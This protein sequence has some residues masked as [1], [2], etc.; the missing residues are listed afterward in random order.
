MVINRKCYFLLFR[1]NSNMLNMS[2]VMS[3]FSYQNWSKCPIGNTYFQCI[4]M[5]FRPFTLFFY[6]KSPFSMVKVSLGGNTL[7][8]RLLAMKGFDAIRPG[9]NCFISMTISVET[10]CWFLA[11]RTAHILTYRS[12]TKHLE[13]DCNCICYLYLC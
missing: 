3:I 9:Y 7:Y 8:L 5:I 6:S 1:L 12:T 11:F 2:L 10:P 4:L 13:H